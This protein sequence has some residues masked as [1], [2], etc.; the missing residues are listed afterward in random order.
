MRIFSFLFFIVFW[1]GSLSSWGSYA[2]QQKASLPPPEDY[3]VL[4]ASQI[5][6]SPGQLNIMGLVE[7]QIIEDVSSVFSLGLGTHSHQGAYLKYA[8]F[9]DWRNQPAFALLTGILHTQGMDVDVGD[10]GA[11][12]EFAFRLAPILSK[13]L[14]YEEGN[15][16]W[17]F[18]L[19]SSLNYKLNRRED[20]TTWQLIG[21][22]EIPA[23]VAHPDVHIGCELGVNLFSSFNYLSVFLSFLMH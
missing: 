4:M 19:S 13:R 11:P 9:P 20:R 17:T 7:K 18:Y 21:G 1:V 12:S 2:L 22:A 16:S 3:L 23:S 8:P 15:S 6:W 14:S 10:L 5:A